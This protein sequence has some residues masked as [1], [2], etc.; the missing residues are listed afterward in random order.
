MLTI[1]LG[2]GVNTA[3]YAVIHAVLLDPL[4]FRQPNELVQVWETHPELRNLQVSVPDYFDWKRSVKSLDLA[5]YTFQSINKASLLGQGV[6]T[7]V[8]GTNASSNL[9][10]VL[11]T[12]PMLGHIYTGREE[13]QAVIL[14]SEQLWRRKFSADFHVIGHALRLGQTSFTIIG[15]LPQKSAFPVWADVWM[16]LSLVE[17]E[18]YSTRKY[19]PLEVIG[20][21]RP[22]IPLRQAEIEM[23]DT[24]RQLSIAN[25]T[26]NGKIG[27]LVVPLMETVVGE[28]RPSLIAASAAVGLVLLIACANLAHLMM[29]RALSRQHEIALRLALGASRFWI[30]RACFLETLVLSWAGGLLGILAAHLALP[31]VQALA[32]GQIPRFEE[33]AI[34]SSVLLFGLSASIVVAALFVAPSYL[35]IFRSDLN[36]VISTGSTRGSSIRGSWLSPV[37]MGS[38]VA[39]SLAVSVAAITLL[40]SFSLTLQTEP[41]FQPRNLLASRSPLVEGD[42]RKSYDFFL[43][44]LA[45]ELTRIPGVREVAAVNAV[46]MSL[47]ATE[48]SRYATRFGIAGVDFAPGRFP[49]AQLRWCTPNYFSVLEIPLLRGRL[50]I[51]TDRNQ[52]RYLINATLARHFFP[53]S[54]PVGKKLLLDVVTPHPESAEIV[55]VVGDVREF[56]LTSAPEP[57]MYSLNVSPE[58]DIVLK[59]STQST[60]LEKSVSTAMQRV[61]PQEASGPART[62]NFYI[63]RSLARQ[64]FI[65]ALIATFAGI[66]IFLCV[67]GIYGVFSYSVTGRMREFGIRSAIG[68]RRADIIAQVFRECLVVLLPGLLAGIG[69]STAWSQFLR[70]M[71]YRVSP[72]DAASVVLAT[73]SVFVFCL[74]SVLVPC[75]RA[76]Q[77]DPAR[78]LRDQ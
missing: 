16:P 77:A 15:V 68:A 65:L 61:N 10:A 4:P 56:G 35:Q 49:T 51:D 58:M 71:L 73:T 53:H 64:Q 34:N 5:A 20:R 21:L 30:L 55:G 67:V 42:W 45:P 41:G 46:P 78:M 72:T 75:L 14:I 8:Q 31:I 76:A 32:N 24:A 18:L 29:G 23:E 33:I 12:K 17:P 40:R 62:M 50:L 1:A 43:N 39:L 26:T 19:H 54:N 69:I 25:P 6:P 38:E 13:T 3:V 22:E 57:T 11:G 74:G 9:F 28:I 47:G 7:A 27:A 37:L 48:H 44:R 52:P 59:T 63:G 60:T 2:I 66:A 70:T 36:R